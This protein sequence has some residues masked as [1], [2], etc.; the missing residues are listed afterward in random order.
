MPTF[1]PLAHP[2]QR[3]PQNAIFR[4]F[5]STPNPS[6]PPHYSATKMKRTRY[7]SKMKMISW[8]APRRC[9]I[10][11]F[12]VLGVATRLPKL[13]FAEYCPRIAAFDHQARGKFGLVYV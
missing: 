10:G 7:H 9:Q 12:I 4:R 6:S 2:R 3:L 13:I 11:V 1:V 8:H 5:N